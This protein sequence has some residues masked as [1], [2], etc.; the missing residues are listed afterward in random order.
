M[1]PARTVLADWFVKV[2]P[3]VPDVIIGE[4]DTVK[5]DG[6]VMAT[7]VTVPVP[8]LAMTNA[9]VAICVVLVP[10]VAVGRGG[11]AGERRRRERRFRGEVAGQISDAAFGDCW[12]VGGDKRAERGGN[13]A[14]RGRT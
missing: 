3:S 10:R 4:P 2:S 8:A 5:S 14:A 11:S 9:V 13:R 12:D 6:V 1:G 7:D